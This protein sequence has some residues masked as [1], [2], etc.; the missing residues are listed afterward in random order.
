MHAQKPAP[1]GLDLPAAI[2]CRKLALVQKQ[3]AQPPSTQSMKRKALF[4]GMAI[5]L[6]LLVAVRVS[7]AVITNNTAL[8]PI[9]TSYDGADLVISNCTVTMDGTHS[10]NSLL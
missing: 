6:G 5:A 1:F 8:N 10:F 2:I 4:C 7:A 9:N 3:T